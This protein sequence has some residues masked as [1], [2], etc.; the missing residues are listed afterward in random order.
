MES[1]WKFYNSILGDII[2]FDIAIDLEINDG[3]HIWIDDFADLVVSKRTC[4]FKNNNIR[5]HFICTFL[6]HPIINLN[7][8]LT[9]VK[10]DGVWIFKNNKFL[11]KSARFHIHL[12]CCFIVFIPVEV[13][14]FTWKLK[15]IISRIKKRNLHIMRE[16]KNTPK[17]VVIVIIPNVFIGKWYYSLFLDNINHFKAFLFQ[18][19]NSQ[20]LLV[21]TKWF[22][23]SAD[24]LIN[25]I[26]YITGQT[27]FY[28]HWIKIFV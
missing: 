25:I 13:Y 17:D 9:I 23:V 22:S 3:N 21:N 6:N 8:T 10:T 26:V 15:E 5:L 7:S 18:V 19:S 24:G 14:S 4:F 16:Y 11:L 2:Q 20:I 1:L 27:W 28:R 12:F